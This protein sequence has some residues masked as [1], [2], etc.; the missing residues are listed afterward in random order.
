MTSLDE[1]YMFPFRDFEEEDF[2]GNDCQG[3]QIPSTQTEKMNFKTF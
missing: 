3:G 2:C 1:D